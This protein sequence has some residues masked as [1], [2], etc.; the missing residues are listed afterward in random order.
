MNRTFWGIPWSKVLAA[1]AIAL[2]ACCLLCGYEFIRSVSQSLYIK[3][4]GADRLP[5][6]MAM[7]PIG[8]LLMVY[9]YGI[10]LSF[11]GAK[12]AIFYTSFLSGLAIVAC[13]LAINTGSRVATGFLYVFR[14]AYIV[15]LVE[16]VWAFINST[17]RRDE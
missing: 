1:L 9:G 7:G 16:Q 8:T 5:I 14:E 6:V 10:L 11:A 2:S 3:A 4:Y 13:Y 15:L 12:R 17:V